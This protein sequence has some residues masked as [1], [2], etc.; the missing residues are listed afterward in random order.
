MWW[1]ASM[2]VAPI[3]TTRTDDTDRGIHL[4][5]YSNLHGRS[6]CPEQL[7]I[8]KVDGSVQIAGGVIGRGVQGVE[9]MV[10][11]L[12]FGTIGDSE[13]HATKDVDYLIG[14]AR[15][16]MEPARGRPPAGQGYVKAFL[17]FPFLLELAPTQFQGLFDRR[18][19]LAA[20]LSCGRSLFCRKGSD[21][22]HDLTQAALSTRELNPDLLES[23]HV[24]RRGNHLFSMRFQCLDLIQHCLTPPQRTIDTSSEGPSA[25]RS[26][27]MIGKNGT[28]QVARGSKSTPHRLATYRCDL[29]SSTTDANAP[30]SRTARSARILRFTAMSAREKAVHQLTV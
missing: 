21:A 19:K 11:V 25:G 2:P 3:A 4:L 15:Q 29:A 28:P 18:T 14:N 23:V 26:V 6:L 17:Y 30:G 8:L 1:V 13:S 7:A 22:A 10:L 12:D 5:H 9:V 24:L 20:S 16:R 27:G